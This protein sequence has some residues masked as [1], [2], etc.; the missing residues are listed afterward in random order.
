[1]KK[2]LFC[3]T[4]ALM[5]VLTLSACGCKHETWIEADCVNPKTCADC[6]ETEGAP[7]GHSWFAATCE[8]A[9]TC[10]VCSVTEGDALGH[11]WVDATCE[12]PKNCSTCGK[13]EGDA[14]GHNWAD[15]TTEAPKTCSA[16]GQTDGERI[17]TDARFTT[18]STKALY[19]TWICRI[20]MDGEM[21]DLEDFDGTLP[22]NL[23][24]SMCNDGQF[25]MHMEVADQE[26]FYAAMK[27]YTMNTMYA[28]FAASGLSEAEADVAMKETYGMTTEEYVDFALGQLDFNSLFATFNFQMVYYVD[29]NTLYTANTWGAEMSPTTFTLNGNTLTIDGFADEIGITQGNFTRVS[30]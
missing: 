25:H 1:M 9:K 23:V 8:N 16:C 15:A 28:E 26:A 27:D 11:S 13:T 10:E 20:D 2:K 21:M 4:L 6:G 30:E 3:L 24:I 18:A 22:V 14:L 17:I 12:T 19:G 29:G 5:L 7:L